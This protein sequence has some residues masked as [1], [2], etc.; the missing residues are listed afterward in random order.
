MMLAIS[1]YSQ[2]ND[3]L[4]IIFDDYYPE[5]K[6]IDFTHLKQAGS[7]DEKLKRSITYEIDQLEKED[8]YTYQYNFTHANSSK[9]EY[10][11]FATTPPC[12]MKKT[13]SFLKNKKVLDI[14]FFKTTSNRKSSELF[15]RSNSPNKT[16]LIFIIDVEEEKNDTLILREVQYSSPV[17]E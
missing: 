3:T 7:P 16:L 15:Q 12:M 14:N 2:C 1:N 13:K 17:K 11:K 9:K 5:M 10:Q 4:F 6:K 8:G